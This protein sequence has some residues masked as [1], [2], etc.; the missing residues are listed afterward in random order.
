MCKHRREAFQSIAL[1]S[2]AFAFNLLLDS[3]K[4]YGREKGHLLAE[5]GP[6]ST[7]HECSAGVESRESAALV[8]CKTEMGG[9][10][11]PLF[12]QPMSDL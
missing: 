1:F 12:R 10:Y 4:S 2:N 6:F 9:S 5:V 3:F 7:W 11:I 8:G